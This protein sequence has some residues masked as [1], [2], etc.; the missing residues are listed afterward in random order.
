MTTLALYT[1]AYRAKLNGRATSG[2]VQATSAAQALIHVKR[3]NELFSN[4]SISVARVAKK[5][6]SCAVEG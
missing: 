1:F 3:M 5:R 4:I 2:T 6:K